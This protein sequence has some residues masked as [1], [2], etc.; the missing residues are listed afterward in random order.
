[1]CLILF[2]YFSILVTWVTSNFCYYK[3][4]YSEYLIAYP[5]HK[6]WIL[7]RRLYSQKWSIGLESINILGLL[8]HMRGPET[9]KDECF[10]ADLCIKVS[11]EDKNKKD[12]L[13]Q[14]SEF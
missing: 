12:S 11:K 13:N 8:I 14:A 3:L 9:S 4:Y 1:M 2:N 10:P 5:P 6:F 7:G